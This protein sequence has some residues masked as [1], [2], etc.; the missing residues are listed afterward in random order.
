MSEEIKYKNNPLNGVSLK[1]VLNEL[2]TQYGFDILFAYLN[3]NCFK[4][5]PSVDSSYKFLKK[6]DWARE[7]VEGFY[8]YEY[9]RLPRASSE[10]FAIPPRDRIVPDGQVPREPADLSLEDAVRLQ[11]KRA[12]KT[13]ERSRG[14]NGRGSF[15]KGRGQDKSRKPRESSPWDKQD[16]HKSSG[17]YSRD[18]NSDSSSAADGDPWANWKK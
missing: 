5:N 6:T 14:S 1:K 11:E 17:G 18:D 8:M 2:V 9:K 7:K 4:T 13:A 3:I 16:N 15:N 12:K 10:Q